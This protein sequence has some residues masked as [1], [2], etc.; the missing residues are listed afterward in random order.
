MSLPWLKG[1]ISGP[2]SAYG[3]TVTAAHFSANRGGGAIKKEVSRVDGGGGVPAELFVPEC[4]RLS[5]V[6]LTAVD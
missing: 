6:D 1:A 2:I 4:M 3:L 5:T